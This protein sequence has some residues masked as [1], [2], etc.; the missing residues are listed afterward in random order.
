[1]LELEDGEHRPSTNRCAGLF[2]LI[3]NDVHNRKCSH[4]LKSGPNVT[5]A[6]PSREEIESVADRMLQIPEIRDVATDFVELRAR[7][8]AEIEKAFEDHRFP[9]I[10]AVVER[11]EARLKNLNDKVTNAIA[12]NLSE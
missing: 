2:T 10:R 5:S 3:C 11:Y 1:M 12:E 4:M 9:D 7:Y 6:Q 8:R